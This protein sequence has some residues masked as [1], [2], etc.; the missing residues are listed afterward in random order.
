M[1]VRNR[2]IA[3]AVLLVQFWP[4][5]QRCR[6]IHPAFERTIGAPRPASPAIPRAVAPAPCSDPMPPALSIQF[7]YF[8]PF[9]RALNPAPINPRSQGKVICGRQAYS[10][11]PT[12]PCACRPCC[13]PSRP[14]FQYPQ[15]NC[16]RRAESLL[17][18]VSSSSLYR[19][20]L[21]ACNIFI[22]QSASG[23]ARNRLAVRITTDK[24]SVA[25]NPSRLYSLP[26]DRKQSTKDGHDE[27]ENRD[28]HGQRSF[29]ARQ[30]D[31]GRVFC[32]S[33]Q[34]AWTAAS[35][36]RIR[37]ASVP[38]VATK[39]ALSHV[40]LSFQFHY[41]HLSLI[42]F[43]HWGENTSGLDYLQQKSYQ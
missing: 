12:P 1:Q 32:G 15:N 29:R 10:T 28:Q 36:R 16:G 7:P 33:W 43:D 38:F 13:P 34:T 25:N 27:T 17:C 24:I 40:N 3:L 9:P 2:R 4:S 5:C 26:S 37:A 20:I 18:C 14:R 11:G 42:V 22:S 31:R 23:L 6:P 21:P 19:M 30:R 8:S 39:A 41:V 35:S